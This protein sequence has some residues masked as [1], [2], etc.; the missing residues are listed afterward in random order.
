MTTGNRTMSGS[1]GIRP[2]PRLLSLPSRLRNRPYSIRPTRYGLVYLA[3]VTALLVG[4]INHNN[5]LGFL[6]TFLLGGVM[7]V[8]LIPAFRNLAGMTVHQPPPPPVFAGRAFDLPLILVGREQFIN[9]GVRVTFD[10][11][12]SEPVDSDGTESIRLTI[13]LVAGKRGLLSAESVEVSSSFP[14]GLFVIRKRLAA[15]LSIPVYPAPLKCTPTTESQNGSGGESP[16]FSN[17]GENEFSELAPYKHGDDIRR[18]HWKSLAAGRELHTEKFEESHAG[19]GLFSLALLPGN[20]L[21]KKL[22]KLC[23]MIMYAES[24]SMEYG[25]RLGEQTITMGRGLA[26]RNQCLKA[27]ALY[28]L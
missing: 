14:M 28:S 18:A 10:G 12:S 26:H 20:D 15:P 17:R 13:P 3:M 4:S 27:L 22:S 7:A 24:A 5:N 11:S 1:E 8:S 21:E 9:I 19:G 2:Q 23:Y 6:L 16:L 25:L